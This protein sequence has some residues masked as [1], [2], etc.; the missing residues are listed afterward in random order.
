MTTLEAAGFA[1]E[2]SSRQGQA[3]DSFDNQSPAPARPPTVAKTKKRSYGERARHAELAVP[4]LAESGPNRPMASKSGYLA[5]ASHPSAFSAHAPTSPYPSG[6][7]LSW[8]AGL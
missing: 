2:V 8:C 4:V 3:S 5:L 1:H 7:P 6:L